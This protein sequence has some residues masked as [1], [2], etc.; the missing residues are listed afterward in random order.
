MIKLNFKEYCLSIPDE[1]YL[2][3]DD[4][5]R[6]FEAIQEDLKNKKLNSSLEIGAGS[7]YISLGL[8]NQIAD[9][10]LTDINPIVIDYL[11]TLKNGYSLNKMKITKSNLFKNIK[12]EFDLIIFNPPYVPS[13][14]LP[15]KGKVDGLA[16]D[17]GAYGRVVILRFLKDLKKHLSENG[18]CY[19]LI[20]SFNGPHYLFKYILKNNLSYKVLKEKNMF[21]EK[22]II[23]R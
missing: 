16:T 3:S 8:Y 9:L 7:G 12:E 23:L 11:I 5:Y 10:T 15:K 6:F 20:S 13:D 14:S 2:P 22:L 18:V 17:G 21:F 4:T 19:L 1:V